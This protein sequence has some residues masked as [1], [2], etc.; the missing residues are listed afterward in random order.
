M[1]LFH[2]ICWAFIA[3]GSLGAAGVAFAFAVAEGTDFSSVAQ[4]VLVLF[5]V[6]VCLLFVLM[7]AKGLRLRSVADLEAQDATYEQRKAKLEAWLSGAL[8]K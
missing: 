2:V 6:G 4:W 5:G 8:R 1:L 7:G 3:L